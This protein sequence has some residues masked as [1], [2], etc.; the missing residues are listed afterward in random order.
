MN[1]VLRAARVV[2]ST[3]VHAPGWVHVERGV[4]AGVGGGSR[5]D[6]DRPDVVGAGSATVR[7]LGD[8]TLVPG[9]VDVHVHGGGGA[10]YPEAGTAPRR[11]SGAA[12]RRDPAQPALIA[13]DAHLVHGTTS[14]MASLVAEPPERLRDQLAA[15]VPL[16]L[17]GEIRGIHLE[18]PWLSPARKGA[19][20]PAALRAPDPREVESLLEAGRGT[21]RMVTVAPE[22]PGAM[23]AIERLTAAGVVVAIGHTEADFDTTVRA[24]DAGATVATHLF[25][26]MPP[27][28]H[29][30]PG[31]ALALLRDERVFLE[32]IDDGAHLHPALVDWVV[33][34]AGAER[35]MLVTDAMA[36]ACCPDGGYRLGALDVDVAGGVARLAGTDTIAGGTATMDVLFRRRAI[37]VGDRDGGAAGDA[38]GAAGTAGAGGASDPAA[39][40]AGAADDSALVA[41]VKLTALTPARAMGWDDAGDIAPGKRA[42]LVVLDPGL[43]VREVIRGGAVIDRARRVIS[44]SR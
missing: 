13:R 8:A 27:L 9:F 44:T 30:D 39:D 12:G 29:R 40:R 35:V 19:H 3:G 42:D 2:T 36:A 31:P 32:L 10:S 33:E 26:A 16:A 14:T 25:N 4:I 1:Q 11:E 15:L 23:E 6:E 5:P 38:A 17:A 24:I 18:G 43:G 20:D 28:L 7:D 41:A 21:I 22:L 37:L 34:S